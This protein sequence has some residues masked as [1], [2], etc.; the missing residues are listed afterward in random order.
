MP[1]TRGLFF[2]RADAAILKSKHP[3]PPTHPHTIGPI[4]DPENIDKPISSWSDEIGSSLYPIDPNAP[5]S[6]IPV[7][8]KPDGFEG[9][10]PRA[11]LAQN[12]RLRLSMLWYYTRDVLK[13][14]ELLSGLQ[15]KA[16][17]ATESTGWEYAI[18]GILDMDVYIRL[19]TV[20]VHLGILPR[21]ETICAHT[22]TQPPGSVFH[23]PSLM[24][25]WRFR[26]CPYLEQGEIYAY[27]GVPL[28]L[29]YE[30]GECV[31][32]GSLCVAS[33]KSEEPLT[34]DQQQ[35]LIRLGD[36]VVSDLLHAVRA[37]RQRDRH[38]MAELLSATQSKLDKMV[39]EEPILQILASTYPDAVIKLQPTN[40]TYF[41]LEGRK[42][43]LM[44]DIDGG[45]WEDTEYLDTLIANSNHEALPTTHTVRIIASPCEVVSGSSLLMVGSRDFHFVFD[46]VDAWF[47]ETC[48]GMISQMWRKR[49]LTEALRAKEKF[50]RGFSHQVR[51]PIH[52]I[53]GSADLLAE[54]I[55][56][57]YSGE[58][59]LTTAGSVE[60]SL[61]SRL[62]EHS[63]YLNIIKMGGRDLIAIINNMITINRWADI[64]TMDR[65]YAMH[66]V[67][68]L[69]T[70][71]CAGVT[72]L[73]VGGHALSSFCFLHP[74]PT[75]FQQAPDGVVS[76]TLS[77]NSELKQLT[78]DVE[79]NG[80]G[81]PH[82]YQ[83][84]IFEP[85]EKVDM[86]SARAGLGL[87]VASRF[88]SLL[89]G[90]VALMSSKVGRSSHFRATFRGIEGIT[91]SRPPKLLASKLQN[92]PSR[93][94]SLISDSGS[95]SLCT[96][97]NS[98]LTRNGFVSSACL[99][100]SF[101]AFEALPHLEK[102]I[103][104][105]AQ[106]PSEVVAICLLPGLD[107]TPP[108]EQT[109]KN[110]IYVSGPFTNLSL[111]LVLEQAD[112]LVGE[113]E[114]SQSRASLPINSTA[115]PASEPKDDE[116]EPLQIDT[117]SPISESTISLSTDQDVAPSGDSKVPV[118]KS[119][120]LSHSSRPVTLIVDDN[121]INLR[122][123]EM[124]C[125][126]RG[127]P[128]L[129][130]KNGLQAVEIFTQRQSPSTAKNDP[131]IEMI[132]MDLQMPVCDGIEATKQIRTLEQQNDWGRALVLVMTGQDTAMDR[133]AAQ[134]AGGD[135]YLVKPVV[136]ENLD[137]IVKRHF[138]M[139]DLGKK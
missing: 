131:P 1:S 66:P 36:W 137:R 72:N 45:L 56:S 93:F 63:K 28:R 123:M 106:I 68:K 42:P 139:F 14:E 23:L 59:A 67:D 77:L 113:I 32:L 74:R 92:L 79:D 98:F 15:E 37:R 129:S 19:A 110:V 108:L 117:P 124:Y 55:Q 100:G 118:V 136:I 116:S 102:H 120:Q 115:T 16:Y 20:G 94:F 6:I 83:R 30:A 95:T 7:S 103:L 34:K 41:E 85:Y 43:I 104:Q 44:S 89:Q 76:V 70:E 49:L 18:I 88:A 111:A 130:A 78:V 73:T 57:W 33:S 71:L 60:R 5:T 125:K 47:L 54:E 138:P 9:R 10:Y 69:E 52:G 122:I 80:R 81:I 97:F 12:E 61:K 109:A 26:E 3:S 11:T 101:V 48:A 50:L 64:A 46:D 13:E 84:R 75:P 65:H 27:A 91:Y 87:T 132:L 40:A 127:L 39:S 31:G 58:D 25:D 119:L 22:V 38:R 53:L 135:K 62:N 133:A 51:T 35:A 8:D 99:E 107:A 112:R 90:S 2:P 128:Y 82:E 86:H 134:E 96:H 114:L 126:K 105:L 29:Q 4:F 24:E 21:G 17:L 121:N